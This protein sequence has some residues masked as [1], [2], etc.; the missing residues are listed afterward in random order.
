VSCP[1]NNVAFVA[2]KMA[3]A[4]AVA[5]HVPDPALGGIASPSGSCRIVPEAERVCRSGQG[6][7]QHLRPYVNAH[8]NLPDESH[9]IYGTGH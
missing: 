1:I 7:G 2:I 8:G 5:R 4:K 3:A 6:P 9:V